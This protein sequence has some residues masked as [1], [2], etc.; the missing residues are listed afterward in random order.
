MKEQVLG[1]GRARWADFGRFST[2]QKTVTVIAVLALLAGG[3]LLATWR[4][5]AQYAPL[6]SNLAA[7]DASSIADKL[8][9]DNIPYKLGDGGAAIQVPTADVD[10][11]RLA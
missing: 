9:A 11:A 7:A 1:F 6:Y 10:K 5:A 3:Y 8:T 2:G 4:P